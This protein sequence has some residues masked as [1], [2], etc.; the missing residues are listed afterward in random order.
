MSVSCTAKLW[1]TVPPFVTTIEP[2]TSAEIIDGS[3][4]N[5]LRVTFVPPAPPAAAT[6]LASSLLLF[7]PAATPSAPKAS[8][9]ARSANTHAPIPNT[10]RSLRRNFTVPPLLVGVVDRSSRSR[11]GGSQGRRSRWQGRVG[12]P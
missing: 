1:A 7:A 4:L 12:P 3:I 6:F 9:R 2:S 11:T 8:N 10:S 5:S